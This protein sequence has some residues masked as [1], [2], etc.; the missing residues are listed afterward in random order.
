MKNLRTSY[1]CFISLIFSAIL[2][3]GCATSPYQAEA[4]ARSD[5]MLA[6]QVKQAE[7]SMALS[8]EPKIIY[9]GFAMH[10]QSKAFRN[11]VLSGISLAEKLDPNAI[12][13]KLNNPAF[14][15]DADWPFATA[16]NIQI[17]ISQIEK[18]ARAQDKIILLFSSHGNVDLLSVNAS[19]NNYTGVSPKNLLVWLAPLR[20]RPTALILSACYSGSFVDPLKS[21]NRII[22][23]AAAKDRTS[24][25]C[26][27]HSNNTFFVE[28]LMGKKVNTS[29]SIRQLA[30]QA[31]MRVGTRERSMNLSPA[32]LPQK[33]FGRGAQEWSN[34]PL[35]AWL[36]HQH[37]AEKDVAAE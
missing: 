28:E 32:S 24:F 25:G 4:K 11:D 36:S 14:G 21:P 26:Q 5:S 9:A 16:E 29:L 22:L 30:E 20:A 23:T 15:Q 10:S 18:L 17:V 19:S 3:T 2:L 27:F 8:T 34:L 12:V 35:D 37:V 7:N 13:F 1:F 6:I 31:A 33:F